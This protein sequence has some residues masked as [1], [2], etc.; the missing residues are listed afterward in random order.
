MQHR[1]WSLCKGLKVKIKFQGKTERDWVIVEIAGEDQTAALRLLDQEI[2][3]A[4]T[5]DKIGKFSLLRGRIIDSGKN[6][7]ELHVDV[8]VF[9]PKIYDAM[10]PLKSLQTQLLDGKKLP[11]KSIIELF[12]LHDYI[13]FSIKIVTDL[14]TNE[15]MWKAELSEK[16]LSFFTN[17]INS[18]VDRLIVVGIT[19]HDVEN[20]VEA[21]KHRRDIIQ[22]ESI[23]FLEHIIEC[24]LG[25][26]ALGL[27]PKLGPYL[28]SASLKPFLPPKIKRIIDRPSL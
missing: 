10:I 25:T 22:I 3:L 1:L 28:S 20:A 13:P 27:I 17:W 11:L 23:G 8:G 15:K 4:P 5:F 19:R 9:S 7:T 12:C 18:S 16:Q 2:G 6:S 24:K 26:N 14:N 21:S